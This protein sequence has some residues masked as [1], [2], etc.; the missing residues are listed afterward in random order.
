[1]ARRRGN[2]YS[3]SNGFAGRARIPYFPVEGCNLGHDT[4]G[5]D[6]VQAWNLF[7]LP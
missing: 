1:M 3:P 7:Y 4:S 5:L 2:G 6:A